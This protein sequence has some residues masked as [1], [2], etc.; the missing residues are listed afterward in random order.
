MAIGIDGV[1]MAGALAAGGKT[2]AV[3]GNGIDICYPPQHLTLARE[4]VKAGCVITEY[5]PGTKPTKFSFPARNRIISG[6]SS[7]TIV[8]EGPEKSGAFL[9]V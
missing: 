5:A 2:I 4:I 1:A 9:F 3:L 7:A 6:L 8:F